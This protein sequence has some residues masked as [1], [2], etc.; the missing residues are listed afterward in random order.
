MQTQTPVPMPV[1]LESPWW[2]TSQ[3][4][5]PRPDSRISAALKP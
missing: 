3:G 1:W 2:K 5:L 4:T